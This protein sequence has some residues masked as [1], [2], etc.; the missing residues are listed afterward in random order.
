MTSELATALKGWRAR[1]QPGDVG[2]PE[3]ERRT[4][5]LRREEL[6]QLAGISVDYLVRLEQG[7][8]TTPSPQVVGSLARALRLSRPERDVLFRAAGIA[9]PSPGTVSRF[10]SPG[11]QRMLD[12][13][14]DTPVA[15]FTVSWDLVLANPLWRALHGDGQGNLA[16]RQFLGGASAMVRTAE[17]DAAFENEIVGDLHAAAS[18]YP[19]DRELADLV[20]ELRTASERFARLWDDYAVSPRVSERKT[21]DSP[22]VGLLTVDCDILTT[23]DSDLRI[24]VYTA[25][26]GSADADKLDLLRVAGTQLR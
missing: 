6:A 14:V 26:P 25:A 17:E 7:R 20:R 24:V 15:V 1:V 3:G 18:M 10:V 23:A 2:Y 21:L 19:A 4:P 11:I 8:A 13:L 16:R 5:G 12:R 9:P 22:A